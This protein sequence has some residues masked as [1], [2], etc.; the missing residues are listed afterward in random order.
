MILNL[1]MGGKA[2]WIGDGFCNDENNIEDCN[3]DGGD[4]CGISVKKNFCV[5]CT[6][7]GSRCKLA[8]DW[9]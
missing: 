4:C 9:L 3:Y 8:I 7:T 6:C 2:L 5:N 1:G